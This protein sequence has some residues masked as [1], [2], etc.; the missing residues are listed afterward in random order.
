VFCLFLS[1]KC[2]KCGDSA[3]SRQRLHVLDKGCKDKTPLRP[4]SARP[5]G[6]CNLLRRDE[7][8]F[9]YTV[10]A[11]NEYCD[12]IIHKS[13]FL[14]EENE[15][16]SQFWQSEGGRQRSAKSV[17][18]GYCDSIIHGSC[19]LFDENIEVCRF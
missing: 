8:I 19:F 6:P 12:S 15:T 5:P 4:R 18:T 2:Q 14:L 13:C 11:R 9:S 1:Q 10:S 17:E 3:Q 7:K 16:K